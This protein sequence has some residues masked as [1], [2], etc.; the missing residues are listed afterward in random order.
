MVAAGVAALFLAAFLLGGIW[1]GALGVEYRIFG[2]VEGLAALLL[3]YV[4]LH[5]GAL[6]WP[7][8]VWGLVVLVYAWAGTAQLVSML[9]PPPG[10]LQWLVLAVLLYFAWQAGVATHRAR[11]VLALG[12]VALALG[13]L[14]YSILPFIWAR[15][16]LPHTPIF[17]L[18]ALGE[19]VKGLVATYVPSRPLAQLFAL[20]AI[21]AWA[22]AVWLQW[23]PESEEDWLRGLSRGER[24]RLLLW[25]LSGRRAGG[26][27]I[28]AEEVRRYLER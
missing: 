26:R 24:D 18:R 25:L 17:D 20:G 3:V 10:A 21:L 27:E 4:L 16:E 8:G 19:G 15:T 13:V 28:G 5:A 23:P 14:K 6:S 1:V 7:R 9:L 2:L 12:L 11:V 22:L